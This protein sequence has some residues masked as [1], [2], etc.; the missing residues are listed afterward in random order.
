MTDTNSQ[1]V[2]DTS[3]AAA[4]PA[5][6]DVSAQTNVDDLDKLLAEFDQETARGPAAP[7]P[8]PQQ[9]QQP[10]APISEDRLRRI[11][12]RIFKDDLDATIKNIVGDLK[13]P[14]RFSK[15][16]IDQVARENPKVANAF[17]NRANDPASW[18]RIEK[19]LSKEMAKDF[20]A[21]TPIDEPS[22]VDHNAVA[23]AVRGASTNVPTSQEPKLG[24]MSAREGRNHV[25]EKY[26]F[27]PGW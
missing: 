24:S 8:E 7:Q 3:N 4:A 15:G 19:A 17:V 13:I 25:K 9:T 6:T 1:T 2:V 12:D 16:W 5:A 11:E 14:E 20:K 18:N 22:T 27:D 10:V 26:G 23:A 21:L